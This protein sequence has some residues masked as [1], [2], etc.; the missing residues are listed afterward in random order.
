MR[1]SEIY[2]HAYW[3]LAQG[4]KI[5]GISMGICYQVKD[6]EGVSLH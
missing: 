6:P 4:C 5:K 3:K 1:F 2:Y